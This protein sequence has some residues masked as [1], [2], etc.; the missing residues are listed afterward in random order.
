MTQ[1]EDKGQMKAF[2][3]DYTLPPNEGINWSSFYKKGVFFV[4][5]KK[6]Y[7]L[8]FLCQDSNKIPEAVEA[9][10]SKYG[11]RTSDLDTN[12]VREVALEAIVEKLNRSTSG[13]EKKQG[14]K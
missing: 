10:A 9:L 7:P 5:K 8:Y 1:D 11:I 2:C 12:S 13:L 6:I 3:I 14:G 4:D